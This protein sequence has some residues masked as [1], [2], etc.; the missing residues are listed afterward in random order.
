MLCI[1]IDNPCLPVV[2]LVDVRIVHERETEHTA[3]DLALAVDL[4]C[5]ALQITSIQRVVLDLL[6]ITARDDVIHDLV[7]LECVRRRVMR[8]SSKLRPV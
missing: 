7:R 2:H 1:G 8:C 4:C 3:R 6:P 5:P